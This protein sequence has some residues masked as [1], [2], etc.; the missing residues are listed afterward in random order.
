MKI[1]WRDV[2]IGAAVTSVL[3]GLGKFLIGLYLGKASVGSAYG[4]AGSLVVLLVWVY[5]SAQIFFFGAE[6][7]EHYA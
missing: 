4:A 2:W 5:Y 7:T 1:E 3:F 6:F